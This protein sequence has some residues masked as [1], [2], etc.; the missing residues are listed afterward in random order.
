MIS[1]LVIE[2]GEL[3]FPMLY[4]GILT[5]ALHQFQ[6]STLC[7]YQIWRMDTINFWKELSLNDTATSDSALFVHSN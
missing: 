6:G 2:F 3:N 4:L 7:C 5:K 1:Y